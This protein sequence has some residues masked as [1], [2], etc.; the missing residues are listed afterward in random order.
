MRI[1]ESK[2]K[3]MNKQ[4]PRDCRWINHKNSYWSFF[5]WRAA[6]HNYYYLLFPYSGA[7]IISNKF[8]CLST[9]IAY[10]NHFWHQS[11]NWNS[12]N[13]S[14]ESN[15]W[16]RKQNEIS[17][18]SHILP[19]ASH[20]NETK[21]AAAAAWEIYCFRV[22]W[23]WDKAKSYYKQTQVFTDCQEQWTMNTEHRTHSHFEYKQ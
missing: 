2:T 5:S 15:E 11:I 9:T 19:Q 10:V 22:R 6:N 23:R 8:L 14:D 13:K 3:W 12:H 16:S 21:V 18:N 7:N 17:G 4:K 1:F 20:K